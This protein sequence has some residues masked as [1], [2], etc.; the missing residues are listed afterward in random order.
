M[1]TL[2]EA[3]SVMKK[4]LH[5]M[6]SAES[7]TTLIN[8]INDAVFV[9]SE[10]G[11]IIYVNDKALQ[12]YGMKREDVGKLSIVDD[13]SG[14]GAP[15]GDVHGIWNKV[16]SD[17]AKAPLLVGRQRPFDGTAFAVSLQLTKVYFKNNIAILAIVAIYREKNKRNGY[18]G[19]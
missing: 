4:K 11:K 5:E 17:E 18:C 8:N 7:I 10:D 3:G 13:L 19:I 1:L 16:L 15:V 12:L 2:T 9:H 6:L 14:P